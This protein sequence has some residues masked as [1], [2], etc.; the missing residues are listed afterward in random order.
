MKKLTALLLSV[1]TV[2]V[3]AVNG[4]ISVF[5]VSEKTKS[6]LTLQYKKDGILYE[7][8]EVRTYRVAKI[9]SD[10]TFALTDSFKSYPVKVNGVTSQTEW[11]NTALTLSAYANADGITPDRIALTDESGTVKFDG[12]SP[13]M[14]LTLSVRAETETGF[15][16]FGGFLTAVS[17]ADADGNVESDVT[18]YPK[19]ESFITTEKE[20]EYKV[21]KQWK[22]GGNP[23]K[24]PSYVD[25]DIVKD[26]KVQYKE[27]LTSDNNWSYT[28]TTKDDGSS[29]EA[30][31]RN[32]PSDYTV[33]VTRNGNTVIIT[34]SCEHKAE[35]P[36]QTGDTFVL[37]P[38][39]L[40]MCMAGGIIIILSVSQKREEA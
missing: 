4:G 40:A 38:W 9:L 35:K 28:W 7:G 16:V 18:V 22:D 13:G 32:V 2:I 29:W 12:I 8:V 15:T 36:P 37:W 30:V 26:G 33:T 39:I 27:R 34:N 25:I 3:L 31:E 10:G 14:Y 1:V 17:V 23:D 19:G 11:N 24:R 6:S 5:A 20:I 21:V